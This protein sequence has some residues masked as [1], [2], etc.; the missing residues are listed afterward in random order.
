MTVNTRTPDEAEITAAISVLNHIKQH[1]DDIDH[2]QTLTDAIDTVWGL[3]NADNSRITPTPDSVTSN[4]VQTA[5]EF[6]TEISPSHNESSQ[7]HRETG[8]RHPHETLRF[9]AEDFIDTEARYTNGCLPS[10]RTWDVTYHH[11]DNVIANRTYEHDDA[12]ES[13]PVIDGVRY[14]TKQRTYNDTGAVDVYLE[15]DRLRTDIAVLVTAAREHRVKIQGHNGPNVQDET[16]AVTVL[17]SKFEWGMN[18]D[19]EAIIKTDLES[20]LEFITHKGWEY[21][22]AQ[23]IT[24]PRKYQ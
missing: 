5:Y 13:D 10:F 3:W 4:D 23:Q 24:P 2:I 17:T 14:A 18:S 1:E 22:T 21:D 8:E 12:I 20:L 19:T 9:A 6:L 11:D 16:H 15:E 7:H